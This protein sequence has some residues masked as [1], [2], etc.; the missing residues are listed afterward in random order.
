MQTTV[1]LLALGILVKIVYSDVRTRR[2]PNV[3]VGA[4]TALGLV[5]I[6]FAGDMTAASHTF[7]ATGMVFA[8][9][10]LLFWSNVLGGGDAKLL[11][12]MALLAGSRDLVCFLFFS[13]MCGGVLAL[14]ILIRDQL[15]PRHW[16]LL[17]YSRTPS[18]TCNS[19]GFTEPIPSTVPYGVAIAAAGVFALIFRP[20]L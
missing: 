19:E 12:A 5:R 20:V 9:G 15:R 18:A 8:I 14:A 3:L 7:V 16:G 1:I 4:I 2:I 13:S 10:F 11:A 17:R 6:T